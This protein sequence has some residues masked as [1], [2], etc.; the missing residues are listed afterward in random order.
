MTLTP[1]EQFKKF[2]EN[3]KEILII[4]PENPSADTIGGA[5]ALYYLLEKRKIVPTIAFSDNLDPKFNFLPRPERLVN[6]I[7]GARDF[8]LSFDVNR[9]KIT[10]IRHEETESK[11]NIYLTPERGSIDPRDFSFILAK[12]KYD[13]LIVL[14]SP[15]L[16]SIGPIYTSNTDLFFEVPIVNIDHKSN[17]DSFGQINIIDVTASSSSEII[18]RII[19]EIDPL[20]FDKKIA[21]SLLTGIVGETD[22]FQKRNTT[23]KSLIIASQLI[24]KG[25]DQQE[26]IR[27]LYK[28]QNLNVL[29]L[30]GRAMAKLNWEADIKLAWSYLSIDDFIQSRASSHD[31]A[32]I[33]DKL[34]EN[35]SE[36]KI[37]IALFNDTPSSSITLIKSSSLEILKKINLKLGG[38]IKREV[39]EIKSENGNLSDVGN[40]MVE[41]IRSLLI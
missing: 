38:D 11:F 31:L 19:E 40:L 28:T 30:W 5:W 8:V 35:F 22:S 39:L 25:A 18:F 20:S 24:E 17:N 2:L 23:P 26:I 21:S 41:K 7:S 13:L 27:W 32:N 1:T 12:F 36:G 33:L 14:G 15:D 4:V 37:F 16:E 10:K 34:E 29:K 3:S 9:N 6:E